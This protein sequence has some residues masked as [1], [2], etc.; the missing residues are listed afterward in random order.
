MTGTAE[1]RAAAG[2]ATGWRVVGWLVIAAFSLCGAVAP[3]LTGC[4]VVPGA[5]VNGAAS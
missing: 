1:Q 4:S 5:R 3:L 2:A